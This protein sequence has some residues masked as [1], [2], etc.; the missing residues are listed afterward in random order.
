MPRPNL[1]R[2]SLHVR[3]R[4]EV[5]EALRR[6]AERNRRSPGD[7]IEVLLQKADEAE[8][9]LNQAAFQSFIAAAMSTSVALQGSNVERVSV[10]RRR[11]AETAAKIFGAPPDRDFTVGQG[12]D[13]PQDERVLA[14]FDAYGIS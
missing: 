14:L 1:G 11:I 4:P 8:Y 9:M 10:L 7:E 3:L 2:V 12:G 6:R 13:P 5:D